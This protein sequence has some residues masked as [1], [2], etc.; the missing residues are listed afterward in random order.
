MLIYL[1]PVICIDECLASSKYQSEAS[2]NN[3]YEQQ[4]NRERER[5]REGTQRVDVNDIA[6]CKCVIR[7]FNA[8]LTYVRS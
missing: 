8:L 7:S 3:Y 5:D 4:V 2:N 6:T 1:V